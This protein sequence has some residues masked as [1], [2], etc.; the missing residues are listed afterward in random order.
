MPADAVRADLGEP[1]AGTDA[2]IIVRSVEEPERFEVIYERH[3]AAIHRYV[4]RR[5]GPVLADDLAA[6]TFL[7]A[8]RA[9]HRFDPGTAGPAGALPWL[10]GIATNVLHGHR[11]REKAQYRAWER[12]GVDPVVAEDH[13]EGVVL[14]VAA[15][16][17]ARRIGGVLARLTQKERDV[18]LL[19]VWEELSYEQTAEALRIPV[20]TV[21]SRLNRARGRLRDALTQ[22]APFEDPA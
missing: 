9:R 5:I 14:Q 2:E 3:M 4:S 13:A 15:G 1:D 19:T 17:R 6:E 22:L 18:L 16:Q 7:L 10:Y 21:R 12:T 11:R 8:F 20:G